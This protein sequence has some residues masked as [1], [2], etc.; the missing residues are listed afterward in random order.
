MP[1]H[2]YYTATVV[3]KQR[4]RADLSIEQRRIRRN[5]LRKNTGKHLLMD[6]LLMKC[7]LIEREKIRVHN[8]TNP[9][10]VVTS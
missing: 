8:L 1:K 2:T 10:D 6:E 9:V 5:I 3:A 4:R 7:F